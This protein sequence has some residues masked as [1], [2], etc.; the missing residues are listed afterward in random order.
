MKQDRDW[1]REEDEFGEAMHGRTEE[2]YSIQDASLDTDGLIECPVVTLRDMVVYPHMVS[3]VFVGRE[4]I[5]LAIEEAQIE[6]Q[7]VIAVNQQNPE[8][9]HPDIKDYLPIGVEMAVGRLLNMPDGF[10]TSQTQG[11]DCGIC[12]TRTIYYCP[13]KTHLRRC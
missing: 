10:G 13:G 1:F 9:D 11:R 4:P 8:D 2:L 7:T 5:L 12:T 6:E 3:P